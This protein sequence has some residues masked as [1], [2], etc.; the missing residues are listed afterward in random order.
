MSKHIPQNSIA[1]TVNATITK[2][3]PNAPSSGSSV[4]VLVCVNEA[5]AKYVM[6]EVSSPQYTTNIK[7]CKSSI[8]GIRVPGPDSSRVKVVA[9]SASLSMTPNFP[10]K[11]PGAHEYRLVSKSQS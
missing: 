10:L 5:H 3:R 2:L 6:S 4:V 8:S 7:S 1:T 9:L 11:S